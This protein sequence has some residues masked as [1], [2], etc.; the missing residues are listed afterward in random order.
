[1]AGQVMTKADMT[2]WFRSA[3][4]RK[5][6]YPINLFSPVTF[7]C[8]SQ[9]RTWICHRFF[10]F[11]EMK[12][13]VVVCLVDIGVLLIISLNLHRLGAGLT[14]LDKLISEF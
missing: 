12:R 10:V 11:N 8:L 14:T 4:K 6:W 2:L 7:L 13:D 1:M 3:K 9:A 5:G